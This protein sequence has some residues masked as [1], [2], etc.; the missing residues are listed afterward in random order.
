MTPLELVRER[1]DLHGL[2]PR[3]TDQITALCPAHR[4]KSP[5]LSAG[6]GDGGQAVL[7]CHA[8]CATDRILAELGL[9]WADVYP[10]GV[11]NGHQEITARY[12]YTDE[13]GTLLYQVVRYSPK[14]FRQRRPDAAGD[15][16]WKLDKTRRVLFRLPRVI[17]AIKAGESIYVAEGEKDVIALERAGV[18]A[19]CNS[20]GAGKWRAEHT[21]ALRGAEVVVVADQ[22][23][24]GRKHADRIAAALNGV[25]RS[26]R[27]VEP[28]EGKDASD[29]L[30]AGHKLDEFKLV[31]LVTDVV[32]PIGSGAFPPLSSTS[33]RIWPRELGEAAYC[34][35]AGEIVRAIEPHT[36]ADPAAVL[37]SLLAMFGN[38][39]GRGPCFLAGDAE[40][41]TN[42]FVCIVGDTSSGRKG[43]SAEGPRR[44]LAEA[45]PDWRRCV[46]SGL[47]SGEGVIH[48]VRD[49]RTARQ[50]AKSAQDKLR[51]DDDGFVEE[52]VDGGADDRRLMLLIPEF[53]QVLGVIARKDNTLSAV[54]RDFWDRGT[55]QTLSKNSPERAT[56]ALVSVLAHITPTE[57]QARLD[58]TEIANGFAN[59]FVFVAAKRSKLLPRG[60]SI[61]AADIQRLGLKLRHAL[62]QARAVTEMDMTE[63]AWAIWDNE[64]ERLVTRPLGL[65]G[66]ITGRAAPIVR[67][68]ALIYALMDE[69]PIV[70]AEHLRASV[71]MWR[72][73]EESARY[74]FGDRLGDHLADRCLTA[75][76]TARAKG[77]TRTELREVLGNRVAAER[78]ADALS[79]LGD[80]GIA[81]CEHQ[82]TPGRSAERWFLCAPAS[83]G[84]PA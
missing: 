43:T 25:A 49:P 1:L 63:E 51:A 29:H 76:R 14:D 17:A 8:G 68:F 69:R 50:K 7:R 57:L 10:E 33:P 16:T 59:R 60:G 80:A 77:L 46:S 53:A 9:T 41:A 84:G 81:R 31:E 28:I 24:P 74:V 61:P 62:T 36:E 58:S 30:A 19:T 71:E 52:L 70:E 54:L 18:T 44:L 3:G 2:N 78:I 5:S 67:R 75:L 65:V 66:A 12:D 21:E 4:D 23:D 6:L 55:A 82:P 35:L 45:D 27:V 40:H 32:E 56:G 26:V 48:H 37:I 73:V 64:Y 42:V 47:V 39:I 34:A 15:W 20:G 38:A 83:P 79:L 72:Y 22:D 11:R 13:H